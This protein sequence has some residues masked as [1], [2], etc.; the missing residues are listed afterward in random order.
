MGR[1]KRNPEK[2]LYEVDYS[3]PSVVIWFFGGQV[4]TKHSS[5]T[6]SLSSIEQV[7]NQKDKKI[8]KKV[9]VGVSKVQD[10]SKVELTDFQLEYST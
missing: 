6:S 4:P 3:L 9:K 8:D 7:S 5:R 2:S 10:Y 1:T